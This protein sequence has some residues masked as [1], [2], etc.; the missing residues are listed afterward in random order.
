MSCLRLHR[1][2]R[3]IDEHIAGRPSQNHPGGWMVKISLIEKVYIE[4]VLFRHSTDLG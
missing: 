2:T 3:L 4:N 1:E